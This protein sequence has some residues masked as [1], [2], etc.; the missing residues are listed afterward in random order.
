MDFKQRGYFLYK[1]HLKT[2]ITEANEKGVNVLLITPTANGEKAYNTETSLFDIPVRKAITYMK[3]VALETDTLCFDLNQA[4]R[5]EMNSMLS[6]GKTKDEVIKYFHMVKT[7]TEG[8]ETVDS[9]HL[10]T[11][12]AKYL[13]KLIMDYVSGSSLGLKNFMTE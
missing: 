11:I 3:E 12:G 6:A 13:S 5:D 2:M 8:N 10:N 1:Q 9:T 4:L 7:D